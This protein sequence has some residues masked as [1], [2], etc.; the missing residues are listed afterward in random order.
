M[1]K[2]TIFYFLFVVILF[3][4]RKSWQLSSFQWIENSFETMQ[5]LRS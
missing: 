4:V 2:Q 1:Q 3:L 5:D